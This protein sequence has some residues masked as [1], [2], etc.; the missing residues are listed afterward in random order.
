MN[1]AD[2]EHLRGSFEELGLVY[3][4]NI[5]AAD[6]VV[7]NTCVVRQAAEDKATG[8]LGSLRK[9]RPHSNSAVLAVMGCMV[10][11]D[12]RSLSQRFPQVNIWA[13]PQQ[14]SPIVEA[15]AK[16]TE[17]KPD[18]CLS[19]LTPRTGLGAS[20]HVPV[21]HGCDKFCTFCI[22]PYRRGREVS[23][24][25]SDLKAEVRQLVK[26]GVKEITLLGQNVD[27]YG[28]DLRPRKDLADLL[29]FMEQ[30][31]RLQRIRF[32]TSHPNDMSTRILQAIRDLPKVCESM[33][34]PFQAGNNRVLSD[35]RR[36]YSS[37]Q[38]LEKVAEVR[39]TVPNIT[40]VTDVIV[41]FP[42]ESRKQFEDTLK[43]L[44]SVR[45]DKVHSAAYSE[46]PGAFAARKIPDTIIRAE[47]KRRLHEV[48]SLQEDIQRIINSKLVGSR[49]SILVDQ[50]KHDCLSGR[51][52]GDK[53]V[54]IK[55]CRPGIGIGDVVKAEI[56]I[57]S[58]WSLEAQ[59]ANTN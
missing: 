53:L 23:R 35:M 8:L 6:V 56:T 29:E 32:L 28:H 59:L 4:E 2:S 51:T 42:T 9:K 33:S 50:S 30:I 55:N 26:H 45:F 21:V 49:F 41:G 11:V 34:L 5:H 36:G 14:F 13:R 44:D 10:G 43:I 52:R 54:R 48:N 40:M 47:K 19:G 16:I 57:T 22:I 7:L 31:E 18:G 24:P 25:I 46:R 3:T 27:S 37:E 58:P 39:E 17:Q 38:Y 15:A 1:S 12:S 20:V